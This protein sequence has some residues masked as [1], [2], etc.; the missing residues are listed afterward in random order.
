[1]LNIPINKNNNIIKLKFKL[2]ILNKLVFVKNVFK[3]IK[4]LI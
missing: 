4:S 1:M 2:Y 3:L